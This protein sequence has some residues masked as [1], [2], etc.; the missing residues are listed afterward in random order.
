MYGVENVGMEA[1]N[2]QWWSSSGYAEWDAPLSSASPISSCS[3]ND[4]WAPWS[5]PHKNAQLGSQCLQEESL[6]ASN[7]REHRRRRRMC[8]LAQVRQRQAANMRERRR[9]ASINDA[10][11]GLRAHIPTMPYEK[12]LS[13]VDTLRLAIGYIT[14]LSDMVET[15]SANHPS[16]PAATNNNNNNNNNNKVVVKSQLD[17]YHGQEGNMSHT[18]TEL[19]WAPQRQEV[20]NGRVATSLWTP[21]G[22]LTN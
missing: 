17:A 6:V 2:R 20:I 19:S 8:P 18:F 22:T 9:M 11:E 15:S 12:R 10:F 14:F 13:K 21:A 4:T 3:S 1:M 7:V 16:D 5:S